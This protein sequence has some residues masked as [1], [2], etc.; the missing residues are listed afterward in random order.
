MVKRRT[1]SLDT[2]WSE[3]NEESATNAQK[4][5]TVC[6]LEPHPIFIDNQKNYGE[7]A[8]LNKKNEHLKEIYC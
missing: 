3:G 6:P 1:I 7:Q 5:D 2:L 8:Q 4:D